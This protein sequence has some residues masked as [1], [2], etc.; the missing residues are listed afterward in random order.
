MLFTRVKLRNTHIRITKSN[1]HGCA[2]MARHWRWKPDFANPFHLRNGLRVANFYIVRHLQSGIGFFFKFGYCLQNTPRIWLRELQIYN[3]TG[4][5]IFFWKSV[6]Q[7]QNL[8]RILVRK[9]Q[10]Y[11]GTAIATFLGNS[12][13]V[14]IFPS[15]KRILLNSL[16][17]LGLI[18]ISPIHG[19]SSYP[20]ERGTFL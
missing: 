7:L 10:L 16:N 9:L 15:F 3:T 1:I 19:R 2:L 12:T 13:G 14:A 18:R 4:I 17:E 6:R 20:V 11:N 8:P 5:A